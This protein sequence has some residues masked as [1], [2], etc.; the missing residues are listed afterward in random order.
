MKPVSFITSRMS[1]KGTRGKKFQRLVPRAHLTLRLAG[2]RP[3]VRAMVA[4]SR[5][6][7]VRRVMIASP[8]NCTPQRAV[9]ANL[10]PAMAAAVPEILDR[11][12]AHYGP[13][14][15]HWPTEPYEFLVWWHCGYPASDAAC[16]RGWDSLRR[17]TGIEPRQ[18]LAASPAK[19]ASALKPGGM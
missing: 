1:V 5:V 11:L 14:E 2:R 17:A 7:A 13:Q 16:A 8:S 6:T 18:L 10:N 9:C 12:E 4:A 15:P 19:L 3:A